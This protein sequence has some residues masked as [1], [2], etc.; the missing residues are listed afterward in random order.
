MI[1][2]FILPSINSVLH[3]VCILSTDILIMPQVQGKY[4]IVRIKKRCTDAGPLRKCHLHLVVGDSG[5]FKKMSIQCEKWQSGDMERDWNLEERQVVENW[6]VKDER[7]TREKVVKN[8]L[9]RADTVLSQRCFSPAQAQS[10]LHFT[11]NPLASVCY[12]PSF[13]I[14]S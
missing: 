1:H 3:I 9:G 2:S 5:I 8:I 4:R 7:S 10:C 13:M 14:L 11:H 12:S 6:S